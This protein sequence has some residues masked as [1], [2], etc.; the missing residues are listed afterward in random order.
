MGER[1]EC[2]HCGREVDVDKCFF[3]EH[4]VKDIFGREVKLR[5]GNCSDEDGDCCWGM[6]DLV[7]GKVAQVMLV[8]YVRKG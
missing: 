8:P 7:N 6:I 4:S 1:I 5:Q 2:P 3:P